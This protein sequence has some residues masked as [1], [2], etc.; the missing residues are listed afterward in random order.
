MRKL[1]LSPLIGLLVL[2]VSTAWAQTPVCPVAG[3][4]QFVPEFSDEFNGDK[5]DDT[6]WWD[7]NP[8]WVGRRPGLYVRDNVAVKDGMLQIT[9][10]KMPDPMETVE[11]QVRGFHTFATGA[12]KSKKRVKY[13]YF[14]ARCKAMPSYC[15]SAFWFYDP[16]DPPQ[17]YQKG[18]YSEEIDVFEVFGKPDKLKNVYHMTLHRQ[19]TPYVEATVRLNNVVK[20]EK[21]MAPFNFCEGF[22]TFGFLW[23]S[24]VMKWYVDDVERWSV[25]NE[26]HKT[27]LTVNFDS[28]TFPNWSGMPTLEELP[29]TFYVDDLRCWQLPDMKGKP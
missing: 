22:H 5:L 13:G 15:S 7:F 2:I 28:E 10:T 26:N 16:L 18:F 1:A 9:A 27:A 4:W 24:E 25:P 19:E 3:D 6:K 14:E 12:V 8:M 20:G 23:T 29:A 21:W 17:K 11:N